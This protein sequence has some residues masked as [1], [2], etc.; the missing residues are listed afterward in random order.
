M[1]RGGT[2]FWVV[3]PMHWGAYP[4]RVWD[5]G[6]VG[7]LTRTD[8]CQLLMLDDGY[9]IGASWCG[10]EKV[11]LY[12]ERWL[13]EHDMKR[14]NSLRFNTIRD[15]SKDCRCPKTHQKTR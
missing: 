12:Q 11:W 10:I 4:P 13:D 3:R 5:K 1:V 7:V 2:K 6:Q 15:P 9:I 8:C 14:I